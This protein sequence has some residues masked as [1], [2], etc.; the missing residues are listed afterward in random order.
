MNTQYNIF[1]VLY[2]VFRLAP[3][4]VISFFML[5]SLFNLDPRGFVYLIGLFSCTMLSSI[6]GQ[7]LSVGMGDTFQ[8]GQSFKCNTFYL[9]SIPVGT[10]GVV[11]PLSKVPLNVM[12]YSYTLSYLFTSFVAPPVTYKNS[13][14]TLQQ[15]WT[16]LL[17]FIF[18]IFSEIAWLLS[19]SCNSLVFIMVAVAIGTLFGVLWTYIIRWL[20]EPRLQYTSMNHVDVCSKP[21]KTVYRC[22]NLNGNYSVKT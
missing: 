2:L 16:T 15:N 22:R 7:L 12:L 13:I 9:G 3:I 4:V 14:I 6:A 1:N 8:V 21:S 5:Q 20:K 18:L 17:L 10:G 11:E 19:N